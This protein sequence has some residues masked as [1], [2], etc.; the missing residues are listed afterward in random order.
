MDTFTPTTWTGNKQKTDVARVNIIP[1]D[2]FFLMHNPFQWELVE[3]NGIWEWLPDFSILNETAGVNGI[4]QTPN[5]VDSTVT[6][7]KFMERGNQIIDREFGYIARYPTKYG[8]FYYCLRWDIPK[9]I[10][11]KTFWNHDRDGFN[12]WRKDLIETGVIRRPEIEIIESKINDVERKIDRRL[13]NQ[14]IPEIKKEID[15]LY[16]LKRNMKNAF[17]AMFEEKKTKV[18]K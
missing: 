16:E 7:M 18:K 8:G 4:Q 14:H 6:R 9:T 17:Q 12:E 2:P 13:K 11:T 15:G 3:M 1:N 5:G 10:G